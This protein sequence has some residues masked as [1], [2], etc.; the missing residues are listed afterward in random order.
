MLIAWQTPMDKM[1]V[2]ISHLFKVEEA[3]GSRRAKGRIPAKFV[4]RAKKKSSERSRGSVRSVRLFS[5]PQPRQ[6]QATVSIEQF[7]RTVNRNR[8][9]APTLN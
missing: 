6:H 4:S 1:A 2:K 3:I 8:W 5:S 9:K 7:V